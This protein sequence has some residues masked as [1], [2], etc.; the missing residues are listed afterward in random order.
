MKLSVFIC[1][2]CLKKTIGDNHAAHWHKLKTE[3][4]AKGER[5][6]THYCPECVRKYKDLGGS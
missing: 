1:N 2:R 3:G 5:K 6:N 4:W